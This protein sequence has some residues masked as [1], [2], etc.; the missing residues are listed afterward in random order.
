[1]LSLNDSRWNEL[2]HAYG[3]ASDIPELLKQLFTLP[4]ADGNAE[5]WFSLWSALAHQGDVYSAS[6]AAVPHVIAALATDPIKAGSTYF[7]FPA[8]VEC[9]RIKKEVPIPSDLI[10]DYKLALSQLPRLVA[11]ASKR[12]WDEGFLQC[13]LGAIAVAKGQAVVAEAAMELNSETAERF[14]KWLFDQ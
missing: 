9:C 13:A 5:P 3:N 6:F 11:D 12:S 1:M 7:Q 2:E 8:W 4:A 14:L 10:W